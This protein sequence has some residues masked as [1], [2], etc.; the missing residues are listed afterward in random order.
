MEA[1]WYF[2]RLVRSRAT[3]T[4]GLR[5]SSSKASM[6]GCWVPTMD[7]CWVPSKDWSMEFRWAESTDD[8]RGFCWAHSM[9]SWMGWQ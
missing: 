9:E 4:E 8:S 7:F 2:F 1:R 5:V 3:A 6:E